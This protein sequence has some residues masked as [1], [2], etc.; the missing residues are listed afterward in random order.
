LTT[1]DP[2]AHIDEV[3]NYQTGNITVSRIDP[4]VAV[5]KYQQE[6]IEASKH[7]LDKE[8]IAYLEEDLRTPCREEI[9]VFRACAN[10]V[11][12]ATDEI[13]VTHTAP[14]GH[15]L[16]LLYSTEAYHKEMERS[17]GEVPLS[18]QQLLPRLRNPR[19]TTVVIVTLAEATP[20][21]EAS[22]L[23]DDLNR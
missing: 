16:L 23:Q 11:E 17:T 4:K 7:E 15:I 19:E 5:E 1:T 20:V 6:V 14:S 18:V 9:A 13:I 21:H 8:G 12:K 10:L 3:L 22:R 2:A